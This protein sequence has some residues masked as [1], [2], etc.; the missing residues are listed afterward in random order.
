MLRVTDNEN[1]KFYYADFCII[2]IV[3]FLDLYGI[4]FGGGAILVLLRTDLTP[5]TAIF[6]M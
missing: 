3:I 4:V 5:D 6:I 1:V 2:Y